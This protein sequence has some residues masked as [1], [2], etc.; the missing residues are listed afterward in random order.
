[1]A[2]VQAAHDSFGKVPLARVFQPAIALAE[3]G[4]VLDNALPWFIQTKK[5]VLSRF[6]ETRRLFTN[7]KGKF[8]KPGDVFCQ[9]ELAATL[10]KV[11]AR[12]ASVMYDGEWGRKFVEVIQQRGGKITEADMK[13]YRAMWEE[14]VQTTYRDYQVFGPGFSA[15]GGVNSMEALNLLE[16]AN[17]KEYGP[18]TSSAQTLI[19][20]TQITAC[21]L[22]T[23]D[24]RKQ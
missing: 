20:L 23:W 12:G 6:P 8:Y 19:W 15:W 16:R 17:L 13:N 7:Q 9:L 11:A 22:L 2:G 18:C 14:P 5:S 4:F 24:R 1:M 10:K 3:N 21:H